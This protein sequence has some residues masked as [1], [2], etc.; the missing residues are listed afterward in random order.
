MYTAEQKEAKKETEISKRS[1]Q[2]H[3]DGLQSYEYQPPLGSTYIG[4]VYPR[5]FQLNFNITA[6]HAN[7]KSFPQLYCIDPDPIIQ[8]DSLQ[9]PILAQA[10]FS[11]TGA[12]ILLTA[13]PALIDGRRL[14][15]GACPNRPSIVYCIDANGD[16]K[17]QQQQQ[18]DQE[19][20]SIETSPGC[21]IKEASFL[22]PQKWRKLSRQGFS[23]RAPSIASAG[24]CVWLEC[25]S[26]GPHRGSDVIYSVDPSD[27]D[28]K[29]EIRCE[30]DQI[31]LPSSQKAFPGLFVDTTLTKSCS[32]SRF[33]AIA[34]TTIWG[35]RQTIVLHR[36][37]HSNTP[38]EVTSPSV[39]VANH[40]SERDQM[41]N[42]NLLCTNGDDLLVA[43][44]SSPICAQQILLGRV[45]EKD[46]QVEVNW[47]LVKSMDEQWQDEKPIR[48]LKQ[49]TLATILDIESPTVKGT[50]NKQSIEAILLSPTS[51]GKPSPF[52]LELHGGPHGSSLTAFSPALA[53]I[54]LSG[55]ESQ[56]LEKYL[57]DVL[58]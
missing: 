54:C 27:L 48:E 55:C 42:Y 5:V 52:M 47:N 37:G 6:D 23:G 32:L 7:S 21:A 11:P 51:S 1:D 28:G 8:H 34:I 36:M 4:K 10:I 22:R 49:S 44:R 30:I 46:G 16:D 15:L 9:D 14:G 24:K 38:V 13:Y 41:W 29:H 3:S 19:T 45:S 40:I 18:S 17:Q 53:A 26:G 50:E 31:N 33:D 56:I 25:R 12:Q 20:E 57:M 58:G 2:S 43:V 39:S 35:S